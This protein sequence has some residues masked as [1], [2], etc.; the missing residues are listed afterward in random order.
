[1]CTF[2]T[3]AGEQF[4]LPAPVAQAQVA[5]PAMSKEVEENVKEMLRAIL[6]G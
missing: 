1:V 5:R 3:V 4:S 2:E 6:E